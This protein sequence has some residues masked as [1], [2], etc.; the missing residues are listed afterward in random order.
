MPRSSWF[1]SIAAPSDARDADAVAAHLHQL[2]LAV[3]VE[4]GGVHRLAVLG[5][6]L[7]HVADLDAALDREHAL[8]VGRGIAFDDVADV[9]HRVGLGQ[10]AAPV[11][12]GEVEALLVGAADEVAHR[13]HRAVGDD[14]APASSGRSGP[15]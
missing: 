3:L 10:V 1:C 14:L 2:R 4:E 7:E 11:D 8:A 5:A 12:A 6:E 13:G 9:G 15:R